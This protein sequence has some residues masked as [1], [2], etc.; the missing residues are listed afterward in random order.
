[1]TAEAATRVPL[2]LDHASLAVPDLHDAIAE[3]EARFGLRT[4]VT[5]AD[6]Q[7]HGRIHLE[8]SYLEVSSHEAVADWSLPLFF[9]RFADL[10][11]LRRHLAATGLAYEVGVYRGVDGEWDDVAVDGGT[12]PLPILVRR[13]HPPEIARSWPPPLAEPHPC[14]ATSLEAV[15]LNVPELGSALDVY[16]RLLGVKF[17]AA[18]D[19]TVPC[20][21]LTLTSG[22][23]VLVE[24]APA[25]IAGIVLGVGSP[26]APKTVVGHLTGSP[27]RWVDPTTS[28]GLRIGFVE[29]TDA[30]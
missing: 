4:T 23:I 9:L 28:H 10:E 6:P 20:A 11:G 14:G 3:L 24:G 18:T 22:R 5:A 27:V 15:H 2:W 12:T 16:G 8:R 21:E 30:L 19:N 26:D 29:V 25:G 13:T 1:M 7:R 17:L